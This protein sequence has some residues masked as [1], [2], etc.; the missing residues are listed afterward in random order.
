MKNWRI[1]GIDDSFSRD[2][3]CIV[4]CVMSGEK[5]EGF[6]YEEIS[7][8]GL[9]STEKIVRMLK[10]SK[11]YDQIRVVF[12]NG[13]TFGGF[14]VVDIWRVYEETEIP[15]VAIMNRMPNLEEF[16]KALKNFR[17][18]EKRIDIVRR[19]GEIKFTGEVYIQCCGLKY[20]EALNLIRMNTLRGKI[21]ES[22]RLAH[23]VA[24]AIIH[25][26]SRSR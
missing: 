19:A 4:C 6:M 15:V 13:I 7:I 25:G 8:D 16:E 9:D 24:S 1:A 22:L 10:K 18:Y 11:F 21:P 3:C 12:L 5:V 20:E 23:L 2:F 17:D 14:N 26:E